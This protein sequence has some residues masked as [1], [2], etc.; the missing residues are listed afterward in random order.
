MDREL[1]DKIDATPW[2]ADLLTLFD[3]EVARAAD[4]PI[5]PVTLPGG[6]PLETI[7]GDGTGGSFLLVGAGAVRPVLYVGSEGEGGLVATNLRD[8]LALVVGVSSLHDATT[9]SVDEDDGRALRDFLARTDDEIRE[10]RPEL[11]DDRDRLREALG[12][13]PV[14][15]VLLRSLQAA[16][17]DITYRPINEQG[18]RFRPML[19]WLED[20]EEAERPVVLASLSPP[21]PPAVRPD[22]PMPG[23][24]GLF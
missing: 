3:F 14:D 5:E 8:A 11:D 21:A 22:E 4:G 1:L 6:Q 16:A 10:D 7:A 20:A 2:I 18:D 19:A 24:L 12:L 15:D 9:F 13:P 17:A 23:Q